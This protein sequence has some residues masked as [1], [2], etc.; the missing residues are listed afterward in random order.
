[1][2]KPGDPS[3]ELRN[4]RF[5]W[6]LAAIAGLYLVLDALLDVAIAVA[7][8]QWGSAAWRFGAA[9]MITGRTGGLVFGELLLVLAF[10]QF[11]SKGLVRAAAVFALLAAILALGIAP[12]FALDALQL[13]PTVALQARRAML[14]ATLRA[15]LTFGIFFLFNAWLGVALL[16]LAKTKSSRSGPEALVIGAR[17]TKEEGA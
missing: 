1:M 2:T 3:A 8:A 14:L 4:T 5:V 13:W 15:G 6:R 10:L 9:G 17:R 12:L 7:P 16:R 11:E